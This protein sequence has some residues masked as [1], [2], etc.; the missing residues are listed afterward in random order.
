M[1]RRLRA[2]VLAGSL[3][4]GTVMALLVGL[5]PAQ[6]AVA[7]G[8]GG[9]GGAGARARATAAVDAM[10][11]FYDRGSGRWQPE[12]PWWQ[13]GNALQA[14]LDYMA[15]TRS[16]RYMGAVKNTIEL[17]RKP[18]P[19]WPEGGGEFRADSTDDT[20]WWALAMVR[21]YD[22]TRDR[23]YLGIA[24][25]DEAYIRKYWDDTCGGG[26]WWDI[27]G[28]SYK[29]AISLELYFKLLAS[30]HNRIPG[31]RVYLARAKQAWRWFAN[32]GMINGE[33]LVDDGLDTQGGGCASNHGT[34][35]TYNQGV[36]LG[37]LAELYRATG[38]RSLLVS[39]RRIADAVVKSPA[40]SP[41]GILTEPC[42]PAGTC[43][44][45]QASFK[46]I[47]ARNLAE[48]DRVVPGHPYRGY[49]RAQA[50][51]LYTRARDG[52]DQ[53]GLSWA[54]PFDRADIARQESAVSLLTAVL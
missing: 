54:G 6:P 52:R 42:E 45:D 50:A 19:W 14:L 1:T 51:S 36:V 12:S 24:K 22:I 17:Q 9:H 7:D 31:D 25:T 53:Y 26:V 29:N 44:A 28:K 21:M 18:L 32:S 40:L 34:T 10:M 38:D 30:L 43:N 11:R 15:K 5:L 27:P 3:I 33:H 13:S 35:W 23:Q 8:R 41:R 47:F 39:A 4:G 16:N 20:G 37:G 2:R 49:L 48:L 46:G